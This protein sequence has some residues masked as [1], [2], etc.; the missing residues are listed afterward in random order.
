MMVLAGPHIKAQAVPPMLAL[1]GPVTQVLAVPSTMVQVA[2]LIPGQ[3]D[4][5]TMGLEALPTTDLVDLLILDQVVPVTANP[6]GLVI[7]V[8]EAWRSTVLTSAAEQIS[9]TTGSD[10]YALHRA[11]DP[12]HRVRLLLPD[13][14]AAPAAL[15]F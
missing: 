13:R 14:P 9:P 2:Q 5:C 15:R 1:A 11:S 6:E 8:Q 12:R 10:S 7:Q 3:A 4:R